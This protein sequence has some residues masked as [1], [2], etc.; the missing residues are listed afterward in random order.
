MYAAD[1]GPIATEAPTK[2]RA[3]GNLT[4]AVK[5]LLQD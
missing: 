3:H 5:Y 1:N 2:R 4:Q